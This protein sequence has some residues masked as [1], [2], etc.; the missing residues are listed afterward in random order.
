MNGRIVEHVGA[1]SITAPTAQLQARPYKHQSD[2]YLAIASSFALLM[3][4]ICSILYKY[5]SLTATDD[6]REKMSIEQEAK[7][8]VNQT[9]LSVILLAS[10]LGSLLFAGVLVGVQIV[11]EI[12][13]RAKLRRL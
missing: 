13:D 8:I 2:N 12:K 9:L 4:F 10:V 6:L 1:G 3:V 11:V 7:Y 5:D